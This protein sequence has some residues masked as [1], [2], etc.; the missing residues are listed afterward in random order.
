MPYL[1]QPTNTQPTLPD[2]QT[3]CHTA[4]F[5]AA[6]QQPSTTVVTAHGE[7]DAANAQHFADFAL[8]HTQQQL[9]LDLTGVEFFGTAGFSA[10]HTLNVRCA[11]ADIAW[12]LVPGSAVSRLLR[13]CDPDATLPCADS[14]EAAFAALRGEE[15]PLLQLVAESG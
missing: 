1:T 9:V 2:E 5:A 13:I 6:A 7:L 12:V 8:R 14:V 4:R 15:R 10:L 11:G 3:I